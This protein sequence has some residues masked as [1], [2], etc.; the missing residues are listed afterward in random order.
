MSAAAGIGRRRRSPAPSIRDCSRRS[1]PS[2]W[3]LPALIVAHVVYERLTDLLRPAGAE[4]PAPGSILLE[5]AYFSGVLRA[6][7]PSA[8]TRRQDQNGLHTPGPGAGAD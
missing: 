6:F 4:P 1:G 5:G 8:P 2:R 7:L 3:L